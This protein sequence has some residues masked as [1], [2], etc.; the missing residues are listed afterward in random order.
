MPQFYKLMLQFFHELKSSYKTDLG[1]D[2]FYL[3]TKTFLLIIG[4]SFTNCRS[5]KE[6]SE[7]TT[8]SWSMVLFSRAVNLSRGII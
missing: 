3:T 2:L 5:R 6:F 1:Q 8:S 4:L 7:F